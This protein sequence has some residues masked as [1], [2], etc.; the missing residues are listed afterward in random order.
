MAL[1]PLLLATAPSASGQGADQAAQAPIAGL[2]IT[3]PR[4]EQD[5]RSRSFSLEVA[6]RN[7]TPAAV[8]P[9]FEIA[10]LGHDLDGQP[11]FPA[12][13]P[14]VDSLRLSSSSARLVP[15]GESRLTLRG[16]LPP[17][18]AGVYA[19]VVV[20]VAPPPASASGVNV[21]QRLATLVL[22]RGPKPWKESVEVETVS[23]RPSAQDGS[24]EVF[25]QLRNT[26]NVHVRPTG[27]VKVI[28]RGKVFDTVDLDPEVVIP[29]Y[30]RR[31]GGPFRVPAGFS[32]T[33]RLEATIEGPGRPSKGTG[34]VTFRGGKLV[35]P[36]G[37]P[38]IR[39]G[40]GAATGDDPASPLDKDEGRSGTG[41]VLLA[42][43]GALL[44]LGLLVTLIHL[45]RRRRH[46]SS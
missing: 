41:R 25:A 14:P 19:G 29:T 10:G 21:T 11:L 45:V 28:Y 34:T 36:P 38:G 13:R 4:I 15:G 33:V 6:F 44:L 22:L 16:A 35:V 37:G 17:D 30:A 1:L 3:P 27:E 43:L 12:P 2:Q 8:S 39:P 9:T 23:A 18:G 40:T 7:N 32:G 5:L 31:L 42:I 24:V 20:S 46:R 26:G